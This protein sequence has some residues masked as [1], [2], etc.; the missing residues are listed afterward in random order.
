MRWSNSLVKACA[1]IMVIAGIVSLVARY[2]AICEL[3]ALDK[4]AKKEGRVSRVCTYKC[5]EASKGEIRINL[6]SRFFSPSSSVSCFFPIG[7]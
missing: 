3:A 1:K 7:S 6:E 4:I 5:L 2:V